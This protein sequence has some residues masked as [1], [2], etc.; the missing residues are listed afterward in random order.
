MLLKMFVVM[1]TM[2]GLS[3][4]YLSYHEH[5]LSNLDAVFIIVVVINTIWTMFLIATNDCLTEEIRNQNQL[6]E[7]FRKNQLS[8]DH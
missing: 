6:I 1:S 2:L 5:P 4:W 3:A 8:K 7:R